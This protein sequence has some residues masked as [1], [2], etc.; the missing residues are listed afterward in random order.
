LGRLDRPDPLDASERAPLAA[1]DSASLCYC[2]LLTHCPG[3]DMVGR[4]RYVCSSWSDH[5]IV[6]T[7]ELDHVQ[8]FCSAQVRASARRKW[9]EHPH[10]P[11]A[12]RNAFSSN[13][14]RIE[15]VTVRVREVRVRALGERLRFGLPKI[16]TAGGQMSVRPSLEAASGCGCEALRRTR[17]RSCSRCADQGWRHG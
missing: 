1:E 9:I 15:L 8:S 6:L 5:Q 12:G 17:L 10:S 3:S 13:V 14:I 16:P 11:D 7:A 4:T 2:A